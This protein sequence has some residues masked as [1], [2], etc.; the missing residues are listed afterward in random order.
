MVDRVAVVRVE[1]GEHL[2][3]TLDRKQVS[4]AVEAIVALAPPSI[5]H[6]LQI[7]YDV[8]VSNRRFF[9]DLVRGVRAHR[10]GYDELSVTALGSW[11][12]GDRW[13]SDLPVDF[14]VPMFFQMGP[15]SDEVRDAVAG[16]S[17]PEPLCSGRIGLATDE[18]WVVPSET[19]EVWLFHRKSWDRDAWK[20]AKTQWRHASSSQ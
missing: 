6:R 4:E 16:R 19:A 7:D 8:S 14:A 2:S 10:P 1:H 17:V 3:P 9:R 12:V 20:E 15:T 5:D 18:K 11:C 13:L